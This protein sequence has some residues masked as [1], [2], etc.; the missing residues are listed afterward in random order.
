VVVSPK[1]KARIKANNAR[2]APTIVFKGPSSSLI[3]FYPQRTK[4]TPL[5]AAPMIIAM[6]KRKVT[7]IGKRSKR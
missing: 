2:F 1:V 7:H 4:A 5:H 6:T 3:L